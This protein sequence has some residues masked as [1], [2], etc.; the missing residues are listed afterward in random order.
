MRLNSPRPL[1]EEHAELHAML[2][3]ATQEIGALGEAAKAVA[4][5]MHPHFLREE[6]FAMPP[7]G[8]LREIVEGGVTAEHAKALAITNRLRDE[9]PQMLEDHKEIVAA[10]KVLL[11]A[12]RKADKVEYIE[13]ARKLM[14]HI[15]TEE[16]VF[17]P[18]ALLVGEYIKLRLI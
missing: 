11:S 13:F 3:H 5:A 12:A 10:L 9:M 4:K 15:R 17:Y 7:L 16:E 6:Q 2:T 18:A 8:L 14:L 1:T